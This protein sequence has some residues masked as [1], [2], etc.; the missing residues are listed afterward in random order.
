MKSLAALGKYFW[1][2]KGYLMGGTIFVITSN[3]FTIYPAQIIRLAMDMVMDLVRLQALY[4]G[5]QVAT[6]FNNMIFN[7]LLL[8]G[9]LMVGLALVRGVLLFYTRQ[10][11]IVMSRHIE[12]EIRKDIYEHLQG[13]TLSFYRKNRT[14]DIMARAAEDVNRVR[15]FLGPA[16]MYTLNTI[17]LFV[18]VLSAMFL[19]NPTLTLVSLLPLPLLSYSIYK[20][21]SVVEKRT[22]QLQEQLSRLNVFAQEMYSGIRVVKAYTQ[23]EQAAKKF[24]AESEMY[25]EKAMHL[26]RTDAM[27]FPVVMFLVGLSSVLTIWVGSELVISG[28]LTIGN[29]AE[30]MI[31]VGLLAWPIISLGW[32][33]T[34]IQ[35]AAASQTRINELMK[36]QPDIAFTEEN[37]PLTSAK[38]AF[39]NVSFS[40]PENN[41]NALRNVSFTL[42]SGKKLGIVGPAGAGKTTLCQLILRALEASSGEIHLDNRGISTLSKASLRGNIGYAPQDVFLFSDTIHNN[43]AFGKPDATQEEVE[44]AAKDAMVYHN[45]VDFSEGFETMIG[46]RG[47]NLSGGQKQ[48]IAIARAWIRKPLLLILDD[49]LSAVDTHTEESIL[50]NL[51]NFRQQSPTTSIVQVAHRLSCIQD[52]DYILVLEEGKVSEMGTHE[53]LISQG[54]Y[55]ARIHEKQL[56]ESTAT[57]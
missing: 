15:M 28:K 24:S 14:G 17:T 39:K 26:A 13:L 3:L 5:S 44:N 41:L 56:L 45:I 10:T 1:K 27:F 21:Q 33:T 53:Q 50:Q 22:T 18:L 49:V 55:Y 51:R 9:G 52:A 32:V 12:Y 11:L 2:Y 38:L 36:S 8:S 31:Y 4:K 40:Y 35:Q 25:K 54:G 57:S 16:V 42:E 48:R 43:I 20:V 6:S 34:L 19:V 37:T 30:F 23:E 47:V 46:E 7:A 29:I